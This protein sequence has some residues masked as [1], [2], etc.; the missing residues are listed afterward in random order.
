[1]KLV[2]L[3]FLSAAQ[4][5]TA[6]VAISIRYFKSK[7]VSHYH[8]FLYRDDGKPIRQ[9]TSPEDA[10]DVNPK[11]SPDGKTIFFT[12]LKGEAEENWRIETSG[13]AVQNL[14]PSAGEARPRRGDIAYTQRIDDK[15]KAKWEAAED[16]FRMAIPDSKDTLL[17]RNA[18]ISR[19]GNGPTGEPTLLPE[20]RA[21][22][23]LTLRE[24]E[25][26]KETRLVT[27]R[28]EEAFCSWL[29]QHDTP[30]LLRDGLR[31]AF[32]YQHTGSTYNYRVAA[33]DLLGKR[34]VPLTEESPAD[35]IPHGTRA[36][37]FSVCEERY[38]PLPGT[39]KTVNCLYLDWWDAKFKK[40]SFSK[41]ISLFGGAS[42]RMEGQPQL[43]IPKDAE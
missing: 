9:L 8:L 43:E 38:R 32:Y 37:F 28:D 18:D 13:K 4:L 25:S 39:S 35:L 1:M 24:S 26:G 5:A 2:L 42:V 19:F 11:F 22:Q 34:I 40:V 36:G 12:R 23:A 30:F 15:V 10:H 41:A 20:T 6:D 33:I 3:L 17:L 16:G 21:F 27:D 7:G 14:G 31:I 29:T